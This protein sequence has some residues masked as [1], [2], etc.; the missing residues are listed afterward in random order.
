MNEGTQHIVILS[1]DNVAPNDV[2]H[3]LLRVRIIG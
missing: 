1:S 3:Y 2:T